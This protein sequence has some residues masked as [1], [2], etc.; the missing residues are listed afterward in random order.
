M[1]CH[2]TVSILHTLHCGL[3]FNFQFLEGEMPVV[4]RNVVS[5]GFG[6]LTRPRFDKARAENHL[7]TNAGREA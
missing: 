4:T 5:L 1:F 2:L 6:P 3:D 7:L